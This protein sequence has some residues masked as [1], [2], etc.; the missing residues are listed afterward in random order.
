MNENGTFLPTAINEIDADF[1]VIEQVIFL[2][3]SE[4]HGHA[5]ELEVAAGVLE[6]VEELLRRERRFGGGVRRVDFGDLLGGDGESGFPFGEEG[7]GGGAEDG[8]DVCHALD[9]AVFENLR[10]VAD[11]PDRKV[12]A[13]RVRHHR[14]VEN[15]I[16]IQI[17]IQI[18]FGLEIGV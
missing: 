5:H 12:L 16:Q 18:R 6:R 8:E 17:E 14:E 1:Q 4:R 2:G 10:R 11:V 9:G 7:D 13:D 15:E 3:V